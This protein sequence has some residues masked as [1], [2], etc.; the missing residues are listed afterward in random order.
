[1]LKKAEEIGR[2]VE[3]VHK[4]LQVFTGF[5][6]QCNSSPRQDGVA[7]HRLP[8]PGAE[9]GDPRQASSSTR[10]VQ[11]GAQRHGG[12]SRSGEADQRGAQQEFSKPSQDATVHCYQCG[13][14]RHIASDPGCPATHV[15]CH[16]C[17]KVGH[18]ATVCR[19][20]N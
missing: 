10:R 16:T 11:D 4:E 6:V 9:D 5:P 18:C 2:T 7:N 3:Q 15:T 13:P 20:R 12:K 1:M 14:T 19:S 8:S 17:K